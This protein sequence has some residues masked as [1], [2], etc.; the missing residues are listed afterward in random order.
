MTK[1]DHLPTAPSVSLLP[2]EHHLKDQVISHIHIFHIR[3]SRDSYPA[4]SV[5]RKQPSN[6]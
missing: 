3:M 5:N 2:Y 6:Y 4:I 1:Q